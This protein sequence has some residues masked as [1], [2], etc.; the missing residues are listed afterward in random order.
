[1]DPPG[2]A[3]VPILA[4]ARELPAPEHL[5][6]S[7]RRPP[8]DL[9]GLLHSVGFRPFVHQASIPADRLSR[10]FLGVNCVNHGPFMEYPRVHGVSGTGLHEVSICQHTE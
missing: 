8:Q 4:L 1:V 3:L 7:P 10:L 5:P 9:R 6:D 2:L